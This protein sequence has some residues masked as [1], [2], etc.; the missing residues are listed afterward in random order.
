M[1]HV[2]SDRASMEI[3]HRVINLPVFLFCL[4][5]RRPTCSLPLDNN[6]AITPSSIKITYSCPQ[7]SS[8]TFYMVDLRVKM[9]PALFNLNQP[10]SK[11]NQHWAKKARALDYWHKCIVI[12]ACIYLLVRNYSSAFYIHRDSGLKASVQLAVHPLLR[13][14]NIRKKRKKV[15]AL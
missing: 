6:L 4:R 14:R 3:I 7:K 13:A 1:F 5:Q 10:Q 15:W 12:C 2:R 11:W 8:T 9:C